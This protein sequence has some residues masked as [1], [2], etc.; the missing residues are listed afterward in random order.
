MGS[1]VHAAL[2]CNMFRQIV[3][4]KKWWLIP[5][6]QSPY[7][8]PSINPN[9]FSAHTF[10]RIGKGDEEQ[11]PWMKKLKRWEVVLNPGDV[12]LNPPWIWHGIVNVE[13]GDGG[14]SIGVP[15]RYAADRFKPA[16]KNNFLYSLIGISCIAW[17]FGIDKFTSS[18]E[19]AQE[20]IEK[21]RNAR[22]ELL[23]TDREEME[24][25]M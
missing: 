2:G 14:L 25:A 3:G 6:S 11:S 19:S 5:P 20:G 7:V 23:A 9:G 17:N 8:I 16:L 22:A 10:T 24:R 4:R 18:A 1:D 15:T 21:A 12:M 13:G